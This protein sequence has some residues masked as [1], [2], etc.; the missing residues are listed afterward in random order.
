[1]LIARPI[2]LN[3]SGKLHPYSLQRIRSHPGSRLP[4][5]ITNTHLRNYYDLNDNDIDLH[6]FKVEELYCELNYHDQKIQWTLTHDIRN[7]W[8]IVST[9][10]GLSSIVDLASLVCDID[11]WFSCRV[12]ALQS[13]VVGSK[14]SYGDHGIHCWW[15]LIRSKQLSSGPRGDRVLCK[16]YGSNVQDTFRLTGRAVIMTS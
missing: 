8:T 6:F 4:K 7:H 11:W 16:E 10:L 2:N 3:V 14:S 13:L 12:S 9:F 5:M 1:M 15:D